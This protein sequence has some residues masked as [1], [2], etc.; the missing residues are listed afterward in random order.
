MYV[1]QRHQRRRPVATTKL[2]RLLV[3][4]DHYDDMTW[5]QAERYLLGR[6]TEPQAQIFIRLAGIEPEGTA[7]YFKTDAIKLLHDLRPAQLLAVWDKWR[8]DWQ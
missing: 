6:L 2:H 7:S 5:F 3:D 1:M 4:V 8:S